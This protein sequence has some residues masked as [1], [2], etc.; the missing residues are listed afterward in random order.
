M[1]PPFE[2]AHSA[3]RESSVAIVLG[4]RMRA[5]RLAR[6]QEITEMQKIYGETD[7]SPMLW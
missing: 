4:R 6:I 7:D 3:V 5:S 2:P 1:P